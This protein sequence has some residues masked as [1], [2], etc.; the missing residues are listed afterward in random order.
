MQQ[1]ALVAFR[2]ENT[3]H[4]EAGKLL[5]GVNT[6]GSKSRPLLHLSRPDLHSIGIFF[7]LTATFP[8]ATEAALATL[9]GGDGLK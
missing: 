7:N 3:L 5:M 9:E 1:L 8:D 2:D 6:A 4:G